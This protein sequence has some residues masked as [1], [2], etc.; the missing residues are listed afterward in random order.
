MGTSDLEAKGSAKGNDGFF[1]KGLMSAPESNHR[2][3]GAYRE[4][5]VFANG[6]SH[7]K[8]ALYVT[9]QTGSNCIVLQ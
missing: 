4:V 9:I 5:K 1:E 7:R 2:A 6:H 3:R 8:P